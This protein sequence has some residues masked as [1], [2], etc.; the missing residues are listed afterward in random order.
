MNETLDQQ[1]QAG[2]AAITTTAHDDGSI[3]MYLALPL[4]QPCYTQFHSFILF[5][6]FISAV[7]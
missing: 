1:A 3:F 5:H 2:C 4:C 6:S 7:S